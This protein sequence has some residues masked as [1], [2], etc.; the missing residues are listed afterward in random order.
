MKTSLTR[1]Q[2][3]F[4][5]ALY[6][7]ESSLMDSLTTQPGF[8]VYRNTVL[9]GST[10]ALLA[11]FPTVE[12][13][14]GTDWLRSAIAIY[15]R[16]SPPTDARLLHYGSDFPRFL[17]EFEHAREMPYLGGVA[18]LDLLWTQVHCAVDESGLELNEL[19]QFPETELG[20][21]Q[22][23]PRASARWIW[24][25]DCP[26]Y[27]IWRVNRE[28]LEMPEEL[29]WQGEGALLTR[30]AGRVHWQ[31]VSVADCAFLDACAKQLPLD[32]AADKAIEAEPDLNLENL[33][34]CLVSADAFAA[35]DLGR[36]S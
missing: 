20:N 3:A 29:E 18:R 12:R 8:T 23:K 2:D 13:L 5:D 32:L 24:L 28:Q 21:L 7:T 31:A 35:V 9:K 19:S 36:P 14:V 26:A 22:L 25:P 4:V 11:N 30:K 1:F 33:I 17:D 10:D 34:I 27:T 6:G 16:L 15:A